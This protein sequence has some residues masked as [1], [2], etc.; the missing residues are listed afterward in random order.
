MK[1]SLLLF[2]T[3]LARFPGRCARKQWCCLVLLAVLAVCLEARAL[4]ADAAHRL[5]VKW[6]DG[7]QSPAAAAGNVKIGSTVKRS[8]HAIGWQ[9]VE[10]PAGLSMSEGIKAYQALGTVAFVEPD[11]VVRRE[12]PLPPSETSPT[13]AFAPASQ[14]LVP[15]DPM[16]SQQWYLSK[17]SATNAW[18]IT[19]GS[20]NV[21]VA[22]FDRGVNYVH[23]DLAANM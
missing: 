7:P 22:V 21:V 11:G 4:A 10:L 20:T 2:V 19:T 6:K 8:Y 9:L 15:N 13:E 1:T 16:F 17:I 23:P 12:P 5:L 3:L 18:A 14:P